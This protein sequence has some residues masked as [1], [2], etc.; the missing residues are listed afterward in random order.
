MKTLE[1]IVEFLVG[2]VP[3]SLNFRVDRSDLKIL[4]SISQQV[5]SNVGLTDR[6]SDL[7]LKKIEKYAD[8][9][10]KCGVD[11]DLIL[12]APTYRIPL[13]YIDRTQA[14]YLEPVEGK[15]KPKIAI[16]YVF[17][18]IFAEIWSMIEDD[19]THITTANKNIK[20]VEYS[21]QNLLTIVKH[22]SPLKFDIS[23][24]IQEIYKK[25]VEISENPHNFLPYVDIKNNLPTL[26]NAHPSCLSYL[27]TKFSNLSIDDILSYANEAK[28]CGI[29]LKSPNFIKEISNRTSSDL[30]KKILTESS[31]RFRFDESKKDISTLFKSINEIGQWPILVVLQENNESFSKISELYPILTEYIPNEKISVFFRLKDGQNNFKEFNQFV[32]DN[33]LNNYIDSETKCVFISSSRIPK[34][35]MR[36]DWKPKTAVC[37][38]SHDYGKLGV[39]L[40]ELSTV[41]YINDS[42]TSRHDRLKRNTKIA[43]L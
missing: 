11:T 14:I 22:L 42:V 41:Y 9:L 13:R 34:P 10:K 1:D 38:I 7:V 37:F 19:L 18:K 43:Q 6:Q 5:A 25:M 24:E 35:L 20:E 36:S 21:E 8:S 4:N 12:A 29:S 3:K 23:D 31:T 33:R 16:K 26:V 32:R 17:S 30:T 28:S 15:K 39:Y 2:K 27:E 40:N